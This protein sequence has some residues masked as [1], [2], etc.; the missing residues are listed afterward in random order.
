MSDAL[1]AAMVG[2]APDDAL[3]W[4]TVWEGIELK[5]L[6]VVASEGLW[7]V[8][9]R[10]APGTSI[11]KHRHTGDVHGFTI[12]GS[13]RYLEYGIDYP[14]GTYIYEPAGSVHTLMVPGEA[15][16]PADVLFVMRGANL[17]L[18]DDGAMIVRVDDGPTTLAY[19]RMMCEAQGLPPPPVLER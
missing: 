9:N 1:S 13:W 4:L 5:V 2:C 14:A 18:G 3:P 16:E 8:R 6:R 17:V 15:T 12:S 7:V 10:F 19:Y 11:E